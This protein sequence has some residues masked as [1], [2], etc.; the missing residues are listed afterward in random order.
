MLA[1]VV[2][3]GQRGG[4]RAGSGG[5]AAGGAW[6]VGGARWQW[7]WW[8]RRRRRRHGACPRTGVPGAAIAAGW[9]GSCWVAAGPG[10]GRHRPAVWRAGWRLG[11]P[12]GAGLAPACAGVRGRGRGCCGVLLTAVPGPR[13][14]SCA[15]GWRGT[16][17]DGT[18]AAACLAAAR[19]WRS[20]AQHV[21]KRGRVGRWHAPWHHAHQRPAHQQAAGH[22]SRATH[23]SHLRRGHQKYDV[24]AVRLL[25]GR[26]RHQVRPAEHGGLRASAGRCG[27]PRGC[28]APRVPGDRVR[29]PPRLAWRGAAGC[30]HGCAPPVGAAQRPAGGSRGARPG[31]RLSVCPDAFTTVRST[32]AACARAAGPTQRT[33]AAEQL[34]GRVCTAPCLGQISAAGYSSVACTAV[35]H[36]GP[37]A[38]WSEQWRS[39]RGLRPFAATLEQPNTLNGSHVG[40]R[41]WRATQCACWCPNRA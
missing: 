38:P 24:H 23:H 3:H 22:V 26:Q 14:R 6:Q 17:R 39:E 10:A 9:L 41:C 27:R 2:W 37:V 34:P 31:V 33:P 40:L 21:D 16:C 13:L 12:A 11:G 36:A 35:S 7:W 28:I 1:D 29:P 32:T 20:A 5:R 19:R 8:G 18:C 4:G 15:G 30:C 25:V